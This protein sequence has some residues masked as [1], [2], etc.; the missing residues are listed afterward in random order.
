MK[1]SISKTDEQDA[2]FIASYAASE[3]EDL[4][5]FQIPDQALTQTTKNAIESASKTTSS[6]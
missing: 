6:C 2:I 5:L 3:V 4:L 1:Q